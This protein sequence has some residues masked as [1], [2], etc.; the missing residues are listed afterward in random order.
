MPKNITKGINDSLKKKKKSREMVQR[1]Q[2]NT[3][4]GCKE[5]LSHNIWKTGEL[6]MRP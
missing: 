1:N 4:G 6:S 2:V 5:Q 3:P